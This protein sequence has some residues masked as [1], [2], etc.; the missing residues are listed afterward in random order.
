M[1]HTMIDP[2]RAVLIVAGDTT[3]EEIKPILESN[4]GTLKPSPSLA[5]RA[6]AAAQPGSALRVYLVNKTGATQT[7]IRFIAPGTGYTDPARGTLDALNTIIG[8]S[9]TSRLNNNLRETHGYTY[10]ARSNFAM[11]PTIGSFTAGASVQAAVTGAA[12]KEFFHEFSR[13]SKGD[14]TADEAT[15]ARETVR[16]DT[17]KSMASLDG[18]SGLIAERLRAK[19]PI[20]SI[21]TD[22]DTVAKA[23]AAD[24]NT[25]ATSRINIKQGVLVLVGDKASILNQI[26]DAGPDLAG[27]T[28]TEV[29]AQGKVIK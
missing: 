16:N 5:P 13:L 23:Q 29:D 19:L 17:V 10:G 14:I 1:L 11:H 8:G 4:L 22:L 12:L 27:I 7:Q 6:I 15:K 18:L 2:T 9:F 28:I 20:S 3:T 26:K 25:L 24:L 21:A